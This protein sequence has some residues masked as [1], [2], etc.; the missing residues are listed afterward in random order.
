MLNL[1][2]SCIVQDVIFI[3]PFSTHFSNN[4]IFVCFFYYSI[5]TKRLRSFLYSL[6]KSK[7]LSQQSALIW[8]YWITKLYYKSA[9]SFES[10]FTYVYNKKLDKT[11]RVVRKNYSSPVTA[12]AAFFAN[13]ISPDNFLYFPCES[14]IGLAGMYFIIFS[15]SVILMGIPLMGLETALS[16]FRHAGKTAAGSC[17][18]VSN[19][20]SGY[21][22]QTTGE[23]YIKVPL[24][25]RKAVIFISCK[26]KTFHHPSTIINITFFRNIKTRRS[27]KVA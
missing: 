14:R 5:L 21:P 1:W 15:L 18:C 26:K 9:M 7:T 24:E 22:L 20:Y 6:Q 11:T 25:C 4:L 27:L 10:V 8:T 12:M 23:L 17:F 3:L 16:Q 13:T 2:L 19:F